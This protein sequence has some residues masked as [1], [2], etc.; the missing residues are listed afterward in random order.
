LAVAITPSR[1]IQDQTEIRDLIRQM[2]RTNPLSGAPY[3]HG[4][5]LK[6]GLAVRQGE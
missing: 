6:L 4:E 3:I 5:L 1:T 2:S